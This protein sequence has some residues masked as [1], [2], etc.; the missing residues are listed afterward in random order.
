MLRIVLLVV[1]VLASSAGISFG[2][3]S[4]DSRTSAQARDA[5]RAQVEFGILVA[6]KG[7]WN[8]AVYRWERAIEIDPRYAAP[9]NNLGV[10]YEQQA[11]AEKARQAYE[12]ALSL[13]PENSLIRENFDR[14]KELH[15]HP[16]R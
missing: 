10:A 5:A 2:Q 11:L 13:D 9:H 3:G 15:D 8:E 1:V 4:D 6:Q 12:R 7:L 14:F 16:G